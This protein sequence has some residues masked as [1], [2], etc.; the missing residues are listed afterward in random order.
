LL[1]GHATR[2]GDLLDITKEDWVRA[3]DF[4]IRTLKDDVDHVFVAGFSLGGLLAMHAATEHDDLSGL[5]LLAPSL[6]VTSSTL[7]TQT[8][9]LRYFTDWIDAGIKANPVRYKSVPT[10]AIAE[11]VEL[12]FKTIRSI[13]KSDGVAMPVLAYLAQHDM[14]VHSD[15]TLKVL[16]E[17][18]PNENSRFIY[19][20]DL[21]EIPLPDN[22][23]EFRSAFIPDEKVLHFS[24]VAFPFSPE[25][26][27]FGRNGVFKECLHIHGDDSGKAR[28][29]LSASNPWKGEWGGTSDAEYLPMLRL[30]YNPEFKTMLEDMVD[31]I[32]TTIGQPGA[33]QDKIQ[34]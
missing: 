4:G 34:S 9:W 27:I 30:T 29:C 14:N 5:I 25:N 21:T 22:R 16:H 6:Q 3:V 12:K 23:I 32:E 19:Y 13:R 17:T 11:F 15:N 18:A 10:N 1:P 31:F 7:V 8:L 33:S 26:P 2:P 20:G 28:N 24:H